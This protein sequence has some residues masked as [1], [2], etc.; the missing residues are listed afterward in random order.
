MIRNEGN[1][2]EQVI[3]AVPQSEYAKPDDL[4]AHNFAQKPDQDL[5]LKQHENLCRLLTSLHVDVITI[6]ELE[7]HPNSVFVRDVAVVTPGGAVITRMGLESRQGEPAWIEQELISLDIPVIGR[8]TE[9]ATVEGGDIILA[10]S[11]AFVGH[12][13]RTN[14]EGTDQVARILLRMGYRVRITKIPP[15]YLHIGGA[16]SVIAP[17]R[18]LCTQDVFPKRYFEGFETV[19]VPHSGFSS[20][21]VITVRPNEVIAGSANTDTIEILQNNNVIVHESDLSEFIAG[22]GGPSCLILPILRT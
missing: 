7:G 3:L 10:G 4:T 6:S 1:S 17:D 20:G 16:M 14:N 19:T 11:V 5:A 9:P 8:I 2:L 13:S 22:T 12:S 18:V 15:P 21:N